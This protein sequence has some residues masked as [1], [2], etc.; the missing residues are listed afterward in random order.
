MAT[1][2]VL[3]LVAFI[4]LFIISRV[5]GGDNKIDTFAKYLGMLA[6]GLLLGAGAQHYLNVEQPEKAAVVTTSSIPT[7]QVDNAYVANNNIDMG[8]EPIERDI[9]VIESEGDLRQRE[10]IVEIED[11]S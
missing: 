10:E 2:F 1:T 5:M 11:D 4:I 9:V 3:L 6:V 8:Q 7:C